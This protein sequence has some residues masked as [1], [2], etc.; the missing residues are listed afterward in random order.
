MKRVKTENVRRAVERSGLTWVEV[1]ERLGWVYV[2]KD[3]V[4]VRDGE[5]VKRALGIH[6]YRD[7]NGIWRHREYMT[8]QLA[9]K[10][11]RVLW[12]PLKDLKDPD[13]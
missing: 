5:R 7:G 11:A 13:E 4:R 10:F 2:R 1:A 6:K 9:R 8:E 3:G 12:L